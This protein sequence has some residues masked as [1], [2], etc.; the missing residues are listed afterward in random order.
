M[1][2]KSFLLCMSAMLIV[3]LSACRNKQAATEDS[4]A[5][6]Q[7][8]VEEEVSVDSVSVSKPKETHMAV[9][10]GLPSGV[11]WAATNLGASSYYECGKYYAFGDIYPIDDGHFEIWSNGF[12]TKQMY[13]QRWS[14]YLRKDGAFN[15]AEAGL[16][17]P[18]GYLKKQ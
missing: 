9:D 16:N 12:G 10:L 2:A 18:L 7:E 14:M 3:G 8:Y 6:V 15:P 17:N 5:A 13:V 1:S 4:V 11:K